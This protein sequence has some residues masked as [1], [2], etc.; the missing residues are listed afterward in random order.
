MTTLMEWPQIS[1]CRASLAMVMFACP[2]FILTILYPSGSLC[3][4]VLTAGVRD[5]I[6]IHHRPGTRERASSL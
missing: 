5:A 2:T 1:I 3:P 6:S 4:V